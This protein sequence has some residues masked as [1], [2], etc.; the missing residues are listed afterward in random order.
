MQKQQYINDISKEVVQNL[1]KLRSEDMSEIVSKK[2][3][4]FEQ[5][6]L[7]IFLILLLLLA[8]STWFIN[9]PD[10]VKSRATLVATNAPKEIV[11]KQDGKL[12]TLL[13]KNNDTVTNGQ[14]LGYIESNASHVQVLLL[15]SYLD[16]TLSDIQRDNSQNVVTRFKTNLDNLGELQQSYKLF[17]TS[18]YQ[19][20]DYLKDGFYLKRK[21]MLNEDILFLQK[22][23]IALQQQK[24][25]ML[26][27][28][29]LSEETYKAT[30][31]LL[32]DK[33]ISKQDDRN[34]QS[35]LL[36][37][38]L[39]IPQINVSLLNNE[40]QQREKNNEIAELDHSISQQRILFQQ[41]VQVLQNLV[42]EWENKYIIRAPL[43]GK[44]IFLEPLQ[45]NQYLK[46]GQSIGFVNPSDS[47]YFALINLP[48]NNF[49]KV[50]V[51]QIVQLRFDA[52][53]YAE[54]GYVEGKLIFISEF[55]TDSGFVAHIQLPKGLITNQSKSL[56]YRD[57]LRAEASIITK[58]MRLMERFYNNLI[59][60][61]KR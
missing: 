21:E 22:N 50:E 11:V 30:E 15:D 9:Y 12:I 57:G 4:F 42:K 23:H 32:H 59:N 40:T 52:Y 31:K 24:E 26:K 60:S 44:I 8:G 18:Y 3:G 55:A 47:R 28:L 43:A 27:D 14:I 33:V 29:N 5:W 19:Y 58:N 39:S 37:K 16:T 34:E 10:I 6:A 49:G 35:K 1:D 13:S 41:A 46:A 45:E 7:L 53:P 38:Q 20:I 61:L 51:G 56:Y 17:I 54:Y 2:P 25:L 36:N 48:Q